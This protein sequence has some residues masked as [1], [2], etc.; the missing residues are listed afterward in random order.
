MR[1][2]RGFGGG[3]AAVGCCELAAAS[4]QARAR[5]PAAPDAAARPVPGELLGNPGPGSTGSRAEAS[6]RPSGD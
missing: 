6:R 2:R 1:I 5:A 3:D 4:G